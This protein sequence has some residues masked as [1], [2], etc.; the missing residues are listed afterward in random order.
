M[1]EQHIPLTDFIEYPPEQM[2]ARAQQ[3]LTDIRRRH[4]IRKFSNRPVAREIIEQCILA[5]GS[6]PSGANHQPWHFVA[7]Q[8]PNVKQQ[9]RQ[10]AEALEQGFYSGR[11]GEE[12][13]EALK[14][15]GTDA[16]KA[17]LDTAPWLIAVFSQKRG[18]IAAADDKINYYVHESVGL[19]TGF[20]L[21]A[22]HH[23]GL[24]TLTHTPKPMSFLSKICGRDNENERPYMLIVTGYPADDATV[25]TH[26]MKK[27]SLE[28]ICSFL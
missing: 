22:L 23:A 12:W 19:A 13:L 8:S 6:A 26:A 27:K 1:T 9:I 10:E 5:A 7:I 3:Y 14:P 2:L 17:Y 16:N 20:L 11:A 15:L 4:S 25:P 24:G 18:G 21:Q 28:Q